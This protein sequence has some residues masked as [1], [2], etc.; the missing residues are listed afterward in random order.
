MVDA[1]GKVDSR[2]KK[3]CDK[4]GKPLKPLYTRCLAK[5]SE[6]YRSLDVSSYRFLD[7]CL[8]LPHS[9]DELVS[10]YKT[11]TPVK[12]MKILMQSKLVRNSKKKLYKKS[13]LKIDF[14]LRDYSNITKTMFFTEEKF[15]F[16]NIFV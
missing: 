1:L 4:N 15:S 7:S 12:D 6:T 16:L 8:F 13:K 11:R 9:L 5:N 2:R 14:C 3:L 10:D